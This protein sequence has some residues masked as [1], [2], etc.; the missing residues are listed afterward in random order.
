MNCTIC[1]DEMV[2]EH[3]VVT[4]DVKEGHIHVH[5]PMDD[6]PLI[7]EM[8]DAVHTEAGMMAVESARWEPAGIVPPYVSLSSTSQRLGDTLTATCAVRDFKAA[9]PHCRIHLST[10][11]PEV[12]YHNPYIEEQPLESSDTVE[13]GTGYLTN[14]SNLWDL[15]LANAFRVSLEKHLGIIIPQ[16][17]IKPDIWMTKEEIEAPPRIEG[18]YWIIT[19]GGEPQW[20][21]KMYPDAGWQEVVDLLPEIK[22]VQLMTINDPRPI[23]NNV[24]NMKGKTNNVRELF[25]MFYHAQGT[26]G[27][28]SMHMHLSAAFDN[29]CVVV[30]GAREPEW[31]THYYGHQYLCTNGCLPCASVH[32]CW[33]C[34][35]F[36]CKETRKKLGLESFEGA[37]PPCVAMIKPQQIADAVRNYYVGGMLSLEEKRKPTFSNIVEEEKVIAPYREKR[38]PRLVVESK[39]A[40]EINVLASLSSKGGGEQSACKLVETLRGVGWKVNF[41]PW[42]KVHANYKDAGVSEVSFKSGRMA[43]EMK[44][45]VPLLFYANDQIFDF[46]E[47]AKLEVENSSLVGIAI[48][49]VNGPLPK[50]EWLLNGKLRAV[51]FQNEEKLGEF[52]SDAG[53]VFDR[54]KLVIQPGAI[55]L[56]RFMHI[57]VQ[58][59]DK[60]EP[61]VVLKHCVADYR[62]YVTKQSVASGNRIHVWQKKIVKEEDAVFYR[63]FLK[64]FSNMRFEF[65][66][67]HRELREAFPNEPRMVFHEWDA[68]PVETFLA[69]GHV[70]LYRTSNL[71]RDQYPR[72]VG[73]ALAAGL[74]VLTEPRDGTKDR[75]QHGDTGF[76]CID[77]DGFEYALR[78]M[79][80][81]EEYR[82]DMGSAAREWARYHLDPRLWVKVLEDVFYG[83]E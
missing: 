52:R 74:P 14:K 53:K 82:Q 65:M 79:D 66:E 72:V 75:V 4:K 16:G 33:K 81:K 47:N 60:N 38:K 26:L 45:D 7:K 8:L 69:R 63:R 73:E 13:F 31:F 40:A 80:R 55:D 19:T 42:D 5:G 77:Y 2:A 49:Y 1:K 39:V 68:M 15:H 35:I 6:K 27:L 83:N 20:T 62:K 3:L 25:K 57:Q 59:R 24:I 28:V 11:F 50:C 61:L 56:E 48:N 78:L 54:V 76:Y 21:A 32:A 23:L 46:C 30:A 64:K 17:P 67:A 10:N 36:S 12:W 44:R 58:K 71:W 34:E 41:H 29:P 70:Y 9:Y 37:T 43:T 18:P 51:F 22:F